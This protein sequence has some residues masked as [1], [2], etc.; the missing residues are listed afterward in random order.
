MK[1]SETL[2]A[3]A[4]PKNE[5]AKLITELLALLKDAGVTAYALNHVDKCDIKLKNTIICTSIYGSAA[6]KIKNSEYDADE[7]EITLRLA[8][9][10]ISRWLDKKEAD[11]QPVDVSNNS[12]VGG[13]RKFSTRPY[14]IWTGS[15]YIEVPSFRLE[16]SITDKEYACAAA[17]IN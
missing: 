2:V 1:I 10:L 13:G 14:R 9:R 12:D 17:R 3:V 15:K 8:H 6:P 16:F 5:P 4:T 7:A 11:G